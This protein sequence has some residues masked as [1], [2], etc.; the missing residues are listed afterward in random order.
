[1]NNTGL[2]PFSCSLLVFSKPLSFSYY[3]VIFLIKDV[4]DAKHTPLR[5]CKE[6]ISESDT[7]LLRKP[8][9]E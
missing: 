6:K 2:K 3:H 8:Q 4:C 7:L 5:D 9:N 1:M